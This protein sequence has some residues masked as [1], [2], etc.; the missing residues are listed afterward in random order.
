MAR[1]PGSATVRDMAQNVTP[2]ARV[3][4]RVADQLVARRPGHPLRVAVDGITAAGK[5]TVARELVA[6]VTDRGRPAVHLSTDDFHHPRAHRYRQGRDSAAGYYQDGYD[7]DAF[8]RLVLDPLG[9][10]GKPG[11]DGEPG[12]DG[13]RSYRARIHDTRTDLTIDEPPAIVPADAVVVVDGSFLQRPELAG[14]WD[15][16]VLVD[17]GFEAAA[18]RGTRRDVAAGL[19]GSLAEVERAYRERYHAAGR[20]YL[21]EI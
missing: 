1:N 3:I 21:A 13:V 11:P 9:P 18:R 4:G 15:E 17:T 10:D 5:S 8:A 14:R 6:A 16:I 20:L 12:P 19:F 2:G 7:L